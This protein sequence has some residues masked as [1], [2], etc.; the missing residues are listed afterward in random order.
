MLQCICEVLNSG[1]LQKNTLKALENANSFT[2][3]NTV[4]CFEPVEIP[5]S[6]IPY[7]LI[8][9]ML[10]SFSLFVTRPHKINK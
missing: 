10:V 5:E 6:T 2:S 7:E 4:E 1:I 9:I 3:C 8:A